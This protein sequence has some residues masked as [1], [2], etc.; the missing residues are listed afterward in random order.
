MF[1]VDGKSMMPG[2][3]WENYLAKQLP[4]GSRLPQNFKTFDFTTRRHSLL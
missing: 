2:M 4:E 1:A 3:P